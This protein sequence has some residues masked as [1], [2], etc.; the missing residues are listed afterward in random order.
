MNFYFFGCEKL[1][2][3]ITLDCFSGVLNDQNFDLKSTWT[4]LLKDAQDTHY[5]FFGYNPGSDQA[6]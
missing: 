5:S 3:E 4:P 1:N 6:C 2:K